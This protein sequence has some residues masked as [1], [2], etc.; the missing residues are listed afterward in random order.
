[1]CH[2]RI[3]SGQT[4]TEKFTQK[5]FYCTKRFAVKIQDRAEMVINYQIKAQLLSAIN[6]PY[7]H[8][9][10][11]YQIYFVGGFNVQSGKILLLSSVFI[12]KL[13]RY[14]KI[15]ITL[16][17]I[18]EHQILTSGIGMVRQ[19]IKWAKFL[20]GSLLKDITM[21]QFKSTI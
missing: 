7:K 10:G 2:F 11:Q 19:P 15:L 8:S 1:M 21:L 17:L 20:T 4:S 6:V 3:T 9:F 12:K 14:N 16:I 18:K 13:N 5:N